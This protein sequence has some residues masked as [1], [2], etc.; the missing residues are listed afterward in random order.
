MVLAACHKLGHGDHVRNLHEFSKSVRVGEGHG[1]TK[2]FPNFVRI[3]TDKE[4]V[5]FILYLP[6]VVASTKPFCVWH[7]FPRT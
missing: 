6:Q 2:A 4:Q 5:F 3:W 7:T 1:R